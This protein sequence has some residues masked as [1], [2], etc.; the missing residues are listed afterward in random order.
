MTVSYEGEDKV[1]VFSDLSF[2][3]ET[4]ETRSQ[5][6]GDCQVL[7]WS[8]VFIKYMGLFESFPYLVILCTRLSCNKVSIL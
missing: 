2:S 3:F 8:G 7:G 5:L 1:P 4:I 6:G